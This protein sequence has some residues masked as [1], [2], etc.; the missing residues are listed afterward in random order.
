[1]FLK[2]EFLSNSFL[3]IHTQREREIR[4]CNYYFISFKI[5]F[6]YRPVRFAIFISYQPYNWSSIKH[7]TSNNSSTSPPHRWLS[8][9]SDT[10]RKSP[11][12][13]N[14]NILRG[15]PNDLQS[16]FSTTKMI[17]SASIIYFTSWSKYGV[18]TKL[19]TAAIAGLPPMT[20]LAICNIKKRKYH[21][22]N[23]HNYVKI[24][25]EDTASSIHQI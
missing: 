2:F 18:L 7:S 23:H 25:V 10:P 3:H 19:P 14:F 6:V 17:F 13:C 24:T 22:L 16:G 4:S 20:F 21:I 15:M 9:T 12:N 1:M 5:R 8:F 11:L